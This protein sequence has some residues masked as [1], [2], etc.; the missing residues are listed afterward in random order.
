MIQEVFRSMAIFIEGV[1]IA[2]YRSF[3]PD[4]Q[5][6]GP[7]RKISIFVGQNSSR[8]SNILRFEVIAH[9]QVIRTWRAHHDD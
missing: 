4:I 1:G 3:G 7:F 5:R 8:K 6:I 2:E 9:I